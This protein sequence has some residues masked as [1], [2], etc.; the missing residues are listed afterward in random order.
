ML[1]V[2]EGSEIKDTYLSIIKT[3]YSEPIT[4]IN[5]NGEKLK[6]IP[7]KLGRQSC[8]LSPYPFNIVLEILA[9]AIRHIMAIKGIQIEKEEVRISLFKDNNGKCKSSEPEISTYTCQNG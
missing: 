6:A 7:L 8:P 1:K 5:L 2:L 9:R 4:N 3:I